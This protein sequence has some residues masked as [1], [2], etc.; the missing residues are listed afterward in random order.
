MKRYRVWEANRKVF[1]WPENWLEPELRD[2]QSP[3]F[4]ETMS[5]LLQSDITEDAAAIAAAQ[6]PLQAGGGRQAGAM[7]H[8]F[9]SRAIRARPT[10]LRMSS[11]ARPGRKRK[12]FYRRREYGYWTPWEQIK[13][14]IEDNP[15]LPVVWQDRLLLFW[16]RILK[17]APINP[18]GV[19][20]SSNVPGKLAEIHLA[21]VKSDAANDAKSKAKLTVQ[22][23]LCFSE[24][25]NGK[26]QPTKTSDPDRPTTARHQ[27]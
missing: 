23:V 9:M 14:D 5:E 7:R 6:L 1:L 11:P 16:L 12:Y 20:T 24:Y 19:P 8:L 21:D 17:K 2:D 4:K 18:A 22:A 15:V 13:L 10:T 26:W 3:I 27:L 25:Y